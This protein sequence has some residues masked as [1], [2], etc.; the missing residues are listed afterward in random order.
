MS[1]GFARSFGQVLPGGQRREWIK[2]IMFSGGI[3]AI[4]DDHVRKEPPEPGETPWSP[5][6]PPRAPQIPTGPSNLPQNP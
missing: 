4:E 2:P 6:H 1:P 3:G 5:Q